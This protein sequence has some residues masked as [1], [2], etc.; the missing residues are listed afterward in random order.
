MIHYQCDSCGKMLGTF[1]PSGLTLFGNEVR[2]EVVI[3]RRATLTKAHICP[4]CLSGELT[5]FAEEQ[6]RKE[7]QDATP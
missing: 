2:L 6:A 5:R 3:Y 1:F 4:L 7:P